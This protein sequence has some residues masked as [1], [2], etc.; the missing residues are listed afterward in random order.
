VK[1]FSL[2][3]AGVNQIKQS[4][5]I[6]VPIVPYCFTLQS[7]KVFHTAGNP[8]QYFPQYLTPFILN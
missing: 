4:T 2:K 5:S 3:T 8:T 1:I 6:L 7:I